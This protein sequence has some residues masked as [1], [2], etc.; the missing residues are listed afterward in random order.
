MSEAAIAQFAA[1]YKGSAEERAD[2]VAAYDRFGGDMDA[3]YETVLLSDAAADDARF[4]AVID[5][6]IERG[7]VPAHRAYVEETGK[8]RAARVRAARAEA[9]EAEAMAREM[10]VLGG[11]KAGELQALIRGRQRERGAVF[12]RI[13]EKYAAAEKGG[14]KKG[15]KRELEV[16]IDEDEFQA[17]QAKMMKGKGNKKK[18]VVAEEPEIDEE[19]F[20]KLQESILGKGKKKR[21]T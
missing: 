10:G 14:R 12:D 6:A 18:V 5:A 15:K 1:R 7:Q 16:E 20:R 19:E 11:N 8:A 21:R 9:R 17:L 4:R 13:A 3:L 2:V